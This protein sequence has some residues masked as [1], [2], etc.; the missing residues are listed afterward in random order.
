MK[1]PYL[2]ARDWGLNMADCTFGNNRSTF[3]TPDG[4]TWIFTPM[5]REIEVASDPNA[6]VE[7]QYIQDG[8]GN[9]ATVSYTIDMQLPDGGKACVYN[10]NCLKPRYYT[11]F[12][13]TYGN[14]SGGDPLSRAYIQNQNKM[15]DKKKDYDCAARIFDGQSCT[16]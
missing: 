8:T 16:D 15:N 3:E 14:I 2:I 9:F 11:Y 6:Y 1:Y 7:G 12:V 10:T 4:I 13:D 5:E